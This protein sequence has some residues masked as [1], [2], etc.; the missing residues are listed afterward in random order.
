MFITSAY[1]QS[2]AGG[3]SLLDMIFPLVMVFA[4]MYFMILRPQQKRQKEHKAMLEA[5][6]RGDTVVTQGGLIGKVAKVGEDE[7]E[8]DLGKDMRVSVVKSMIISVRS[9]SEPVK[10]D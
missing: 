6:R 10:K 5:V 8:V 3:G 2:A 1:A 9:K 7:L 4:I